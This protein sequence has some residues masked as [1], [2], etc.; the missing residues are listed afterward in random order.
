[1]K[2][3]EIRQVIFIVTSLLLL[4]IS[5]RADI[6][7]GP[8]L[9]KVD[10]DRITIMW[11]TDAPGE[12]WV[13]YGPDSSYGFTAGS[14]S[15]VTIHEVEITGLQSATAYHYSVRTGPD[16]SSDAVFESAPSRGRSGFR[17]LVYGDSRSN[18]WVHTEVALTMDDMAERTF[19]VNT[20]DIVPS[21]SSGG[22]IFRE[23]FFEPLAELIRETPIFVARGN[24]ETTNPLFTE[25]LAHP[26]AGSGSEDFY[27]FDYGNVHVIVLDTT[28]DFGTGSVQKTWLETDLILASADPLNDWIIVAFHH[29]PYSTGSH[30]S[31]LTV[32]NEL[33]GLFE[34]YGVDIV[35]NGHDHDYERIEQQ[36]GVVYIVVGGGAASLY[37]QGTPEPWS[38]C[39]HKLHHFATVDVTETALTVVAHGIQNPGHPDG[40]PIDTFRI[41][42]DPAWAPTALCGPDQIVDVGTEVVLDGSDSYDGDNDPFTMTWTQLSGPPACLSDDHALQP[43]FIPHVSGVYLFRLVCTEAGYLHSVPDIVRVGVKNPESGGETAAVIVA[44]TWIDE[45]NP[46]VNYGSSSTLNV[47]AVNPQARIYLRFE[48]PA[49]AGKVLS[50]KLR[51][52]CVNKSDCGG[53]VRPFY[54]LVWNEYRPTWNRPL[55]IKGGSVGVFGS[56]SASS[57]AEVVLTPAMG[58]VWDT[59]GPVSLAICEA[60]SNGADYVSREGTYPPELILTY[61]G[62]PFPEI[63]PGTPPQ[64]DRDSKTGAA[65]P[66]TLLKAP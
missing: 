16:S 40:D 34:R 25:Y 15:P 48:V 39:Y 59:P 28:K 13:N 29:P 45:D 20:G 37:S 57:W 38:V 26:S 46:D 41:T 52:Y 1:M 21:S 2:T 11:E 42:K 44:D 4:N 43:A 24:H 54:D 7:A 5:A 36:N 35:F 17:F 31:D 23:D 30:G 18:Q 66:L 63:P 22:N 56:V 12:S 61:S 32:R 6:V 8:W 19:I 60:S 51:L 64:A 47:D 55:T 3:R 9:Q 33:C 62:D 27:S 14:A 50:A 10:V 53:Y 65:P 49:L 58:E